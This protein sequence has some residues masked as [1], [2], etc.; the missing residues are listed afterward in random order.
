MPEL[1]PAPGRGDRDEGLARRGSP[2][3]RLQLLTGA[4]R[5]ACEPSPARG[6]GARQ[7]ASKVSGRALLP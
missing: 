2:R 1:R 3:H 6:P 4:K 7:K 5:C